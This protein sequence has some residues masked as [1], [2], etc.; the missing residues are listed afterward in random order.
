MLK[1][2][3]DEGIEKIVVTPHLYRL[4]KYNDNIEIMNARFEELKRVASGLPFVFYL[5]PEIYIHP[6]LVNDIQKIK[7]LSINGSSYIYIEFSETH[8]PFGWRELV[9]KITLEGLIPIIS[10][11]ERNKA[12][13]ENPAILYEMVKEGVVSM[14]TAR[15]VTG[16]FG[17]SIKKVITYLIS[18]NLITFIATDAHDSQNRPPRIRKAVEEVSKIIGEDYSLAMVTKIPQAI[19]DNRA[20]PETPEPIY[21]KRKNLE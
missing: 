10:H 1:I 4:N 11:P 7:G 3:K 6:D 2:A 14:G 5:S 17:P 20:I 16:D 19:L 21:P 12:I 8:I 18:H 13:Q 15:S 9:F